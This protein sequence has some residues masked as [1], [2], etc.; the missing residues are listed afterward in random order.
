MDD[1]ERQT[2]V[3]Q[4]RDGYAAVVEAL[5]K[6]TRDELD[7]HPAP[8]KW[9]VREIIHHLADSEMTAAVRLRLLLAEDRPEIKGYDQDEF[10]RRLYYD[11]PYEPSLELFRMVRSSTVD[12]LERLTPAEWVRE[13]THSEAGPFGVEQWLRVYAAHAHKHARQIR[14]ARD[15]ATKQSASGSRA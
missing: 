7:V 10:A 12:I 1:K 11:R 13:G 15:A 4:Y 8:G 2:L 5:L 6:I 14:V 9:S 3:E